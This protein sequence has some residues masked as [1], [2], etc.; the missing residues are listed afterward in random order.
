MG[1]IWRLIINLLFHKFP[2]ICKNTA[3]TFYMYT[4]KQGEEHFGED[5]NEEIQDILLDNDWLDMTDKD[6]DKV[7][8]EGCDVCVHLCS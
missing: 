1:E 4:L 2:I 5:E 8:Q 3:E 7:V 6:K